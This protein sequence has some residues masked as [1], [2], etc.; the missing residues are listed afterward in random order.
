[1]EDGWTG[2]CGDGQTGAIQDYAAARGATW[3]ETRLKQ[4]DRRLQTLGDAL[5]FEPTGEAVFE[6]DLSRL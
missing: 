4:H 5:W 6:L 2:G 3:I 1:M